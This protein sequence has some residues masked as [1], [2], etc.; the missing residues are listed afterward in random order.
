[1]C[2]C[3]A[4]PPDKEGR[5]GDYQLLACCFGTLCVILLLVVI[6]VCV[7]FASVQGRDGNQLA[8]LRA[9]QTSLLKENHNL[10]NLIGEIRSDNEGLK[11]DRYN[12]TVRLSNLTVRLGNLTVRLG[13]LTVRLGNLTVRLG[14]LTETLNVSESRNTNLTG[15]NLQLKTINKNLADQVKTMKAAWN[16]F[17]GTLAQKSVDAYC[18]KVGS[19]RTCQACPKD[20]LLNLGNCYAY[21]DA[22]YSDQRTWAGAREDC[23]GKISD[24]TAVADLT[25]MNY[26]F[27]ISVPQTGITGFWIGLRAVN[28]IWKWINGTNLIN[29]TWVDRPAA[30]GQC[31]TSLS[32]SGWRSVSCSTPNAWICEKKA[33][34]V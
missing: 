28:G 26:V 19:V 10:T 11:K 4:A 7:Y 34:S 29:Q 20:W 15:E 31:V 25:E 23:S 2:L 6:G 8:Q 14:N 17:S 16:E 5:C 24:L 22:K 30:D 1:M 27:T 13:N 18:P 32:G 12:L 33:V 9:N 3:S 21:N